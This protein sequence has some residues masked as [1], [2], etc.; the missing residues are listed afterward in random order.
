M[1]LVYFS[2]LLVYELTYLQHKHELLVV[3]GVELDANYGVSIFFNEW[4]IIVKIYRQFIVI[5]FLHKFHFFLNH[6]H[7]KH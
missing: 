3:Q 5:K 7:H 4:S 1:L 2:F 6:A